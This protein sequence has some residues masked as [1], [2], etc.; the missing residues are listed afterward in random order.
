M[1]SR[2][3]Y[4]KTKGKKLSPFLFIAV[5]SLLFISCNRNDGGGYSVMKGPFRQS[6][7]CRQL[8]LPI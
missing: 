2:E 7:N 3:I 5:L 1:K 6:V 8:V 4:F